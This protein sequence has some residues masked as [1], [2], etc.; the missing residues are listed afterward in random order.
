MRARSIPWLVLAICAVTA[1]SA[2]QE[3]VTRGGEAAAER[4]AK[5]VVAEPFRP[6]AVERLLDY[7]ESGPPVRRLVQPAAGFGIRLGGISGGTAL[8]LGPMWRIPDP[9]PSAAAFQASAA[10]GLGGDREVEAGLAFG[11]P[12]VSASM[13]AAGTTLAGERFFGHGPNA[14]RT[15]QTAFRVDTREVRAALSIAAGAVRLST[16]A[17]MLGTSTADSRRTALPGIGTRFSEDDAPGLYRDV[18]YRVFSATAAVDSRDVPGNPRGGGRYEVGVTRYVDA[19]SS[20]FSF[21]RLDVDLE[22]HVSAWK[23]QRVLTLR[24]VGSTSIADRG[25][26]VPFHLQRTLGGSRLLR[27]FVTDRFRDTALL[28]LQAEYGF[29]VLPFV[30][31]VAFYEAGAVAPSWRGLSLGSLRRDYGLGFRFGGARNV[32][33]RTDVAFG[34][35]EGTR[36][37]MRFHHAF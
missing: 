13:R 10:A 25:N 24:A 4:A 34:S 36:L 15:D 17:A 7:V 26:E 19:R 31:T 33:F 1:P 21:T 22:Q 8:A 14:L 28:A 29:D 27:G 3:A 30:N 37:T 23:R 20:G 32:A 12:S 9:F 5:A 18:A 11:G 16:G 2:A 6:G 35:G